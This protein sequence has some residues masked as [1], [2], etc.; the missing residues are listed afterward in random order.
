YKL[1]YV[2]QP[3][4]I[5][6]PTMYSYNIDNIHNGEVPLSLAIE[7]KIPNYSNGITMSEPQS[8]RIGYTNKYN[9]NSDSWELVKT[10]ENQEGYYYDSLGDLKHNPKPSNWV[11]WDF[12][13]NNWIED[14]ELKEKAKKELLNSYIEL[15]MKKDKMIELGLELNDIELEIEEIKKELEKIDGKI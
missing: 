8:L 6:E 9:N 1:I 13:N 14:I 10:Y 4:E 11:K 2:G 7:N 3:L 15:E 5:Q 12:I